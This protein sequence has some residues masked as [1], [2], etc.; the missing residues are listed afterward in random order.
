M[1]TCVFI[2]TTL[3]EEGWQRMHTN[4]FFN[5]LRM[6]KTITDANIVDKDS[7]VLC[8]LS[9]TR[10]AACIKSLLKLE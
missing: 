4:M 1:V 6:N 8:N 2:L 7:T 5:F 10:E 3:K 9:K